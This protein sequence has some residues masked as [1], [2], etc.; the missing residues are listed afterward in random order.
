MPDACLT[1]S[2]DCLQRLSA[3]KDAGQTLVF[4]YIVPVDIYDQVHK[5]PGIEIP[6]KPQSPRTEAQRKKQALLSRIEWRV[7]KMAFFS[8]SGVEQAFSGLKI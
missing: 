2:V 6:S 1:G 5:I 4:S 7:M 8:G 3:F